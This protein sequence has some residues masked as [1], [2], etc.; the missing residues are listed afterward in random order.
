MRKSQ[1]QKAGVKRQYKE[2]AKKRAPG[3]NTGFYA[4]FD[5]SHESGIK[6]LLPDLLTKGKPKFLHTFCT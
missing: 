1:C 2:P 5:I 4:G 3:P 6:Y